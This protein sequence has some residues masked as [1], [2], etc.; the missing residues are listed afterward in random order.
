MA[1]EEYIPN[2]HVLEQIHKGLL[3][4]PS[5]KVCM[6]LLNS[7]HTWNHTKWTNLLIWYPFLLILVAVESSC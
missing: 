2:M 3:V 7:P 6:H 5:K 4:V 1:F